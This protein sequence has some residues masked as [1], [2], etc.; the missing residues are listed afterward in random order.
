M[1]EI[2]VLAS[3]AAAGILF[4][5]FKCGR[6]R[7]VLAFDI[8]VDVTATTLLC[9]GMA[10]TFTGIMIGLTAGTIISIT[11]FIMKK[12]MGAESW[13]RKGWVDTPRPHHEFITTLRAKL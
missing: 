1:I 10:G 7:R 12:I 11:L 8:L 3:I 6:I 9:L 2:I 5:V 13:T 4:I